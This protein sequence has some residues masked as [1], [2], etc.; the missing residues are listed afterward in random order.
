[1]TNQP[2]TV[3]EARTQAWVKEQLAQARA[4]LRPGQWEACLASIRPG[5]SDEE[6]L[7]RLSE[8]FIALR[9]KRWPG[10]ET[11]TREEVALILYGLFSGSEGSTSAF[12]RLLGLYGSVDDDPG[13]D[14]D[15]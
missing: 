4:A 10:A 15:I 6:F 8:A 1:M 5:G 12:R 7:Y 3:P 13:G 11:P 2:A 14:S 9:L